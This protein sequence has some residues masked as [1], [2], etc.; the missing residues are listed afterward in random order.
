MALNL[1]SGLILNTG[2]L[3]TI[4]TPRTS[5]VYDSGL[6]FS[7]SVDNVELLGNIFSVTSSIITLDTAD[8]T[9]DRV[10]AIV[11][12]LSS[13][14]GTRITKV[15]GTPSVDAA[16]PVL[17]PSNQIALK[18]VTVKANAVTPSSAGTNP[19]DQETPEDF[20]TVLIYNEGT[21]LPGE[22]ITGSSRQWLNDIPG[23]TYQSTE[24]A[25]IGSYSVKN[26]LNRAQTGLLKGQ[27]ISPYF[28]YPVQ[29]GNQIQAKRVA[30]ISFYIK[31]KTKL[32]ASQPK[33]I[34]QLYFS[35]LSGQ[36]FAK[37][38][39]YN[40]AFQN[41]GID[42]NNTTDWQ[43]VALSIDD[44]VWSTNQNPN[45]VFTSLRLGAKGG[46][47]LLPN[48]AFVYFDYIQLH[49]GSLPADDP[50]N[51]GTDG[52]SS[53]GTGVYKQGD[54]SFSII[55]TNALSCVT[56][57]FSTV[58]GGQNNTITGSQYSYI[59]AG[60]NNII[61]SGSD[62]I[63]ILGGAYNTASADYSSVIGGQNNYVNH[64]D[65]FIIGSNLTSD[66]SC[67]TFMNNLDVAGIVSGSTFSGSFVGD[68]SGLTNIPT[69][70]IVDFP[71]EVSK[72]AAAAGFGSGSD[73]TNTG[74]LLTTASVSSNTITFT[75]GDNSTFD[76]TVNTGSGGGGSDS[77]WYDGTT[78]ISSSVE[79]RVDGTISGSSNIII[80]SGHIDDGTNSNLV[81]GSNN[82]ICSNSSTSTIVGGGNNIISGSANLI[83][84]GS[85]NQLYSG[86]SFIGG[87]QLNCIK[88]GDEGMAS[89]YSTII[90]GLRNCIL[91]PSKDS[92]GNTIFGQ[93]IGGGTNNRIITIG[94]GDYNSIVGGQANRISGSNA[95]C[96]FIG[97]GS[98]NSI[99][100]SSA[101]SAILGGSSN[102]ILDHEK[103]FIIG[104]NL[105]SN[106]SCYTFMNNLDVEGTVSA[107]IFSGSFVGDGRGLTNVGGGSSIT[108]QD[109]G[110][111]CTTAL[112]LLNFVGATVA[113]PTADEITVTFG[114]GLLE[115]GEGTDTIQ[116]VIGGHV[117]AAPSSSIVGG[118]KNTIA[119]TSADPNFG[120]FYNFIGGGFC[121]LI[122]GSSFST[123]VGSS[124]GLLT[125]GSDSD[126][127]SPFNLIVGG[128][129]NIAGGGFSSVIGGGSNVARGCVSTVVGGFSNQALGKRSSILGGSSNTV[130]NHGGCSGHSTII[131]SKN[132]IID[133]CYNNN[134]EIGEVI[135]GGSSNEITGSACL[136]AILGGAGHTVCHRRSAIVGGS[137]I[138]TQAQ[139][140][141]Y[142]ENLHVTSSF[143]QANYISSIL[144]L[145]R[146]ETTPDSPLE[147]MIMASGSAGSSKLYYYDGSSWNAL[148]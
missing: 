58:G 142:V 82:I 124:R 119:C 49:L 101:F 54:T 21:G 108:L 110:S 13:S 55:P 19:S 136:G 36:G 18:Y 60:Q 140:T 115:S 94:N 46:V 1:N 7:A 29:E 51:G 38:L 98:V 56:N 104:S 96:T 14:V 114:A 95:G 88:S 33:L 127:T 126:G 85:S 53:D 35:N 6:I 93:F 2:S 27:Y 31:L 99:S 117:V 129:E 75:K 30:G 132:S 28:R 16:F 41:H 63:S 102:C 86:V 87:G 134:T 122:S 106:K 12:E 43:W 111:S 128:Q 145:S 92:L 3:N 97:G 39:G 147:G 65:S 48:D 141:T 66:K 59:G 45:N 131:G 9:F 116:D 135:V 57:D 89:A 5:V 64:S 15:T 23:N 71:T 22:W 72:S 68:G 144:T 121:N 70:S 67:Y 133:T 84:G 91:S 148:F 125:T 62:Y 80:G 120:S 90:G 47:S 44:F 61:E 34:T 52:N 103:T 109:N 24:E 69:S 137:L 17:D 138:T 146:K 73:S 123:I 50:N 78:Y 100:G 112:S 79:I 77:D 81:G 40:N 143:D 8:A 107:S 32:T 42:I 37:S 130:I 113:E 118:I 4:Q 74:S 11:A 83:I 139:N 105:S 26:N 25:Y 76:I 20:E 10:D